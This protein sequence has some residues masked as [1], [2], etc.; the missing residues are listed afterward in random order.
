MIKMDEKEIRSFSEI[1]DNSKIVLYGCGEEGFIVR[2]LI[3][4]HKKNVEVLNYIDDYK[5]GTNDGIEIV[6]SNTFFERKIDYDFIIITSTNGLS[7]I[8]ERLTLE[9]IYNYLIVKR[10]IS[11]RYWS[12]LQNVLRAN[13]TNLGGDYLEIVSGPLVYNEAGLTTKRYCP[14]LEDSLFNESYEKAKK[15]NTWKYSDVRYRVYNACW[16]AKQVADLDGDYVECGVSNGGLSLAVMNYIGFDRMK[17]KRFYL[18]DTF[19]GIA[20]ELLTEEEI[21]KGLRERYRYEEC[22]ESVKKRFE[23][24]DNVDVVRGIVPDILPEV[25]SEKVCYLSIDMNNMKPEIE[26]LHF[27]WDKLVPGA[28]VVL[29]DYA[30]HG[31]EV[32]RK[33]FDSFAQDFNIE[34]LCLPTGQG[35]IVKK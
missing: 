28:I 12:E 19:C 30:W 14:F 29:D 2:K 15:T 8:K 24:F 18:V 3:S 25:K 34:I 4:I 17:D 23:G 1:P 5:T 27:F 20:E 9:G 6:S 22:Y 31:H 13:I 21:N 16:A 33:A 10:E 35:L 26:A 7:N 11:S 32:Q